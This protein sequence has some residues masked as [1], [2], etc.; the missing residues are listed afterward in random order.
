VGSDLRGVVEVFSGAAS[1]TTTGREQLGVGVKRNRMAGE[2][3]PW[4][5]DSGRAV[6]RRR[7]SSCCQPRRGERRY[8]QPQFW[9]ATLAWT[10]ISLCNRDR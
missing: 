4:R 9:T 5:R 8:G 10:R 6:R 2:Q 3:R 7:G 1:A